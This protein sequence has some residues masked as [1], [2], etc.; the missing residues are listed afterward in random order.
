MTTHSDRT[1]LGGPIPDRTEHALLTGRSGWRL[2]RSAEEDAPQLAVLYGIAELGLRLE[3]VE[4][5][6]HALYG[7]LAEKEERTP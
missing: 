2:P 1:Y 6:V 4:E 5:A 3:R 7:M